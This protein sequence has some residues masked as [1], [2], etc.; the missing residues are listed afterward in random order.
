MA[1]LLDRVTV[2]V[3][4]AE[5]VDVPAGRFDTWLVELDTGDSESQAWYSQ[6]APY[7]LVKF[8]DGRSGGLYELASFAPGE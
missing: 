6:A 1:G 8:V 5:T 4:K 2:Q 7:P 3:L